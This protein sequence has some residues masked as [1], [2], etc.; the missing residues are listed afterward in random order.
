MDRAL[1]GDEPMIVLKATS[2]VLVLNLN[3]ISTRGTAKKVPLCML[4]GQPS[5]K[6]FRVYW[7]DVVAGFWEMWWSSGIAGHEWT[8][9]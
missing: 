5:C 7:G 3:I 8:N 2:C 4:M 1:A 9:P 6:C